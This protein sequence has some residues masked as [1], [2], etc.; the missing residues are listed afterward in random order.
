M[1]LLLSEISL[2]ARSAAAVASHN[3][4]LARNGLKIFL[5]GYQ[6]GRDRAL[7]HTVSQKWLITATLSVLRYRIFIEQ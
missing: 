3:L 4:M 6:N 2:R 7:G 5:M 1:Y